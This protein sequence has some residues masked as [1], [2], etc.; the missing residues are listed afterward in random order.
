[1]SQELPGFLMCVCTGKCPGF[2]AMD[3]WDFINQVRVELPVEYAF[4]HPQLCEEDGDRFLAD[5]LKSHRKVIIGACAPNMQKKMF[6]DAFKEAGL[7]IL[8]DA[9]MLDIRD[10]T[11]DEAFEKVEAKLEEMGYEV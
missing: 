3:I 1:M 2:Q 10:M 8:E 5:F 11:N 9:V 6:K 4:I 7:D